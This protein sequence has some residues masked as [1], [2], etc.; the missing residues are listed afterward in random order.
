VSQRDAEF[1][2]NLI[3][4]EDV[5]A[6]V[7]EYLANV[8]FDILT[9]KKAFPRGRPKKPFLPIEKKEM[10][11]QEVS[12]NRYRPEWA[13][14]SAAVAKVA[15]DRKCAVSA[16]WAALKEHR[17]LA[18]YKLEE[19]EH[20]AMLDAAYEAEWEAALEHLK[21]EHGDREFSDQEVYDEINEQRMA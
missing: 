6:K 13:K 18:L 12:L 1:L 10:A 20:D 16:V 14:L 11:R 21:E 2:A 17:D 4:A 8:V 19:A 15:H 5:D 3:C 7:R 9:G